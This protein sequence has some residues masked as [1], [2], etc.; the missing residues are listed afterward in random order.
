MAKGRGR[1]RRPPTLVSLTKKEQA[2]I[3]EYSAFMPSLQK[4]RG[5]SRVTASQRGLISRAAK[6]LRYT[7]NLRP[8]TEKQ[9]KQL[10]KRGESDLI[11]GKGIRAVRLRNTAP[12]AKIRVRKSGIIVASNGSTWEYHPVSSDID[13]LAE[14]GLEQLERADVRA[15]A[16]WTSRGR[17][18]E[19][20]S[21]P[22]AWVDYLQRR[23][24]QY[25]QQ[26]EFTKGIAVEMKAKPRNE[27]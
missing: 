7:E 4:L 25:V 11:V 21:R 16:L 10:Q 5:K 12:N 15:I 24:A 9:A 2:Q 19:T 6:K 13:A 18:N 3:R 23:Y 27:K 1:R 22:E 17:V 20:F 14:Y 26:S 8:L